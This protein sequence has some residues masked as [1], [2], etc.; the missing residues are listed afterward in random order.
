MTVKEIIERIYEAMGDNS[1]LQPYTDRNDKS[2]FSMTTEGSIRILA[3]IN[4]ACRSIYNYKFK[5]GRSIRIP[6]STGE[7]YFNATVVTGTA[8]V[9]GIQSITLPATAG[10]NANQY[11]GWIIEI[12]AGTGSGQTRLITRYTA[13]RIATV[14]TVWDT[15]PDETS[16][17]AMYHRDYRLVDSV[18][19]YAD[20]HILLSPEDTIFSVLKLI[21]MENGEL[22]RA[23][24]DEDW[25]GSILDFGTPS[26]F[27][28]RGDMIRF[29][30]APESSSSWYK[31]EYK[32]QH[33]AL[34]SAT[35]VPRIPDNLH[36]AIILYCLWDLNVWAQNSSDAWA[37]K[38]DFRD[39]MES[40]ANQEDSDYAREDYRLSPEV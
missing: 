40:Q 16:V 25:N 36:I 30:V 7:L 37:R 24:H 29:N 23:E 34:T 12:T 9:G 19:F 35:E 39:I 13:G 18:S 31:L 6:G 33:T 11:S 2:T 20:E 8:D 17:F 27:V 26:M 1:E 10:A 4:D 5:D 32:K 14:N 15:Q 38:N 28:H 21:D 3:R 22:K